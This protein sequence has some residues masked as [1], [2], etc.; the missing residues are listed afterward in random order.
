M[1]G[2][3][4]A[5]VVMIAA[6]VL[7]AAGIVLLATAVWLPLPGVLAAW[8]EPTAAAPIALQVSVGAIGFA[9]WAL[10]N[11]HRERAFSLVFL[12]L[13]TAS[14]LLLGAAAYARCP[15]PA[16]SAGWSVVARVIGF[17]IGGYDTSMFGPGECLAG[18]PLALQFARL[19]QVVVLFVAASRAVAVLLRGQ[20]DRVLVRLSRRLVLVVGVDAEA[21]ALLPALSHGA[22]E[23]RVILTPDVGATWVR[24]ARAAGWRVV[25][26]D[27]AEPSVVRALVARGRRSHA[28]ARVAVLAADSTAAQRLMRTLERALDGRHGSDPVRAL[29]RID[30]AWQAEDWRRRYLSRTDDFL[31]DTISVDEVTARLLVEDALEARVDRIVIVGRSSLTFAVLGELAQQSRERKV[32]GD[33]P[34]PEVVVVDPAASETLGQHAFSERRFGNEAGIRQR[35]VDVVADLAAL[36]EADEGARRPALLFT[37]APDPERQRTAVLLGAASADRRIY[38]RLAEVSGLGREPLLARVYAY[39]ST[40]DAGGG[41]PVGN[42]ERIAR[43]G[44]ERYVREH[45]D[46]ANPSRRPWAEL[47]PFYRDSN[48][49]QVLSTLRNAVVVGRTWGASDPGAAEPAAGQAAE[50]AAGQ[51]DPLPAG[52]QLAT[53]A[54]SEHESW[55]QSLVAAGWRYAP[56]RDNRRRRHPDLVAWADLSAPSRE[57]T[58]AGVLSSLQL[59]ATLGYRSVESA[60]SGAWQRFERRGEVHARRRDSPWEWTTTAGERMRGAAG[61]WEVTDDDGHARSVAAAAFASSYRALEGDRYVRVGTVD[62]RPARAG[63]RV[64]TLEGDAVAGAGDWVVRGDLGEHWVVTAERFAAGYLPPRHTV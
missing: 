12:G 24:G 60:A 18:V 57:K 64:Q 15:D 17:V 42:W 58:T 22:G 28:L 21:A 26:G 45:P 44:H 29:L 20:L 53:M 51:H 10:P 2:R 56:V 43:L 13:G 41:R 47:A 36:E 32:L 7:Y 38:S 5:R 40:L 54:Q 14:V 3:R 59:L 9:A 6:A 1:T 39:G 16:L 48:V 31:V 35:A 50:R 46:P 52:V 49:R 8:N 4:I 63:E 33:D 62:A 61:D 23:T 11:R 25:V 37:G 30:D 19:V 55:R 34:V 27:P